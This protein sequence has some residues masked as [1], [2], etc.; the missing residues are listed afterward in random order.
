MHA[1]VAVVEGQQAVIGFPA[2]YITEQDLH[3]EGEVV[4]PIASGPWFTKRPPRRT[5]DFRHP[6]RTGIAFRKYHA[7]RG[8]LATSDGFHPCRGFV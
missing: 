7:T 3:V 2:W 8:T 6:L 5:A 4:S 1:L